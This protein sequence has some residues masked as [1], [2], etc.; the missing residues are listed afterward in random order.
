MTVHFDTLDFVKTLTAAGIEA[1]HAEALARAHA[2]SMDD[3]VS[4]ELCTKTDLH[5]LRVEVRA[6]NDT[7]RAEMKAQSDTLRAEMK[8]LL[9]QQSASL[10]ADFQ[11][12]LRSLRYGASIAMA[13]LSLVVLLTRFIK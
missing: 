5:A 9:E 7:L 2:K 12:E 3:L 8:S 4:N 6:Q 11:T 1:P 10:R 13:F